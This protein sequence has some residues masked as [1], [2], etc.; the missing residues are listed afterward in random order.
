MKYVIGS[1]VLVISQEETKEAKGTPNQVVGWRDVAE[2]ARNVDALC[3]YISAKDSTQL[4][5]V[6]AIARSGFWSAV[7]RNKWPDCIIHLNEEHQECLPALKRNFPNDKITTHNIQKWVPKSG[8]DLSILDFDYF[9]LRKLHSEKMEPM[10]KAW[11]EATSKYVII[12]D[13]ACFGFKFGN[14]K[15]YGIRE[16]KEYYYL[17]R[18][19]MRNFMSKKLTAVSKFNNAAMLLFE[20]VKRTKDIIFIPPTNLPLFKGTKPYGNSFATSTKPLF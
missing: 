5:I 16:E 2:T 19:D 17:L 12:G 15:H 18:E 13:G 20:E 6:D 3:D 8:C 1:Q 4:K 10:I 9:T 14:M 7:F 11:D